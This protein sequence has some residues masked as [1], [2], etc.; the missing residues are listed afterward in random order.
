FRDN[1]GM[2]GQALST[3]MAMGGT[4]D[5]YGMG[6]GLLRL[7]GVQENALDRRFTTGEQQVDNAEQALQ[8]LSARMLES[9]GMSASDFAAGARGNENFVQQQLS[10]NVALQRQVGDF[11]LP[12]LLGRD[13]T[14]TDIRAFEQLSN[15]MIANGGVLPDASGP[16]GAE[17]EKLLAQLG[18]SPADEA[19]K[20]EAERHNKQMEVMGHFQDLMTRTDQWMVSIYDWITQNLDLE[21]MEDAVLATMDLIA[22]TLSEID[23]SALASNIDEATAITIATMGGMGEFLEE[24]RSH[25]F[26]RFLG[27]A[28]QERRDSRE[29]VAGFL[30]DP[31]AARE[32][33]QAAREQRRRDRPDGVVGAIFGNLFNPDRPDRGSSRR[34][35]ADDEFNDTPPGGV[36]ATETYNTFR[37]APGDRVE[38]RRAGPEFQQRENNVTLENVVMVLTEGQSFMAQFHQEDME[39]GKLVQE[40]LD[41]IA[42]L[43]TLLEANIEEQTKQIQPGMLENLMAL[44]GLTGGTNELLAKI[45]GHL[46]VIQNLIQGV[47]QAISMMGGM[48]GGGMVGGGGIFSPLQGASIDQIL[49]YTP[50]QGQS[51]LAYRDRR[52]GPDV[53]GGIDLDRR[54]GGGEGG[55]VVAPEGGTAEVIRIGSS[56][57]GGSVQVRIRFTDEQGREITHRL[58][59]LDQEAVEQ[60]LGISP[61]SG[62]V[63]VRAG[64]VI[65]EVGATDNL[66]RGAHLDWKVLVDGQFVDPQQYLRARAQGGG[67]ARTIG[68]SS[69]QVQAAPTGTPGGAA[70]GI[71]PGGAPDLASG[72]ESLERLGATLIQ[73][74]QRFN[75]NSAQGRAALALALGIGGS[76]VYSRGSTATDFFTRRGGTGDNMLGFAQYNLAYHRERVD[77]P[78]E[79]IDFFADQMYGERAQPNGRAGRNWASELSQAVQSGQITNGQQLI[80]WMQRA[81]L[82]GSNWQ[83]VDDGWSRVPGLADQL[84]EYIQ[85]GGSAASPAAAGFANQFGA[86]GGAYRQGQNQASNGGNNFT[87]SIN[88]NVDGSVGARAEDV[89]NAAFQG[90]QAATDEFEQRWRE[91]GNPRNDDSRNA[92]FA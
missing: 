81:G 69:V 18:G 75:P 41:A 19:R 20:A 67:S 71:G 5:P 48:M 80:A 8:F 16:G 2:A 34:S 83:G 87:A 54:I 32:Q 7:A 47:S 57:N 73:S 24:L 61:G 11:L 60:A 33:A 35:L 51:F 10:Q 70:V 46:P 28:N 85:G 29:A 42:E 65:G 13:A 58:N 66:S 68:G 92:V 86:V 49:G 17:V 21:Q 74:D 25:P 72:Y 59:H 77:T 84:V 6:A 22:S 91:D 36:V 44:V 90:T 63:Q 27:N 14:A 43:H 89:R 23:L 15:I 9:S 3:F 12:G 76:E 52:S 30:D 31:A 26:F 38:A 62:S 40:T 64:Q 37:F 50:T 1:P 79:Y 39:A 45:E 88:V 56:A 4:T 53:H 82:G 78:Q 55:I